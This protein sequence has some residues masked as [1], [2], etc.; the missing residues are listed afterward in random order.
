MG[1]VIGL[2][3]AL[4]C[5]GVLAVPF[6]R[7]SRGDAEEPTIE[8]L[9]EA[10][11]QRESVYEEI[12]TLHLDRG[13]GNV[14]EDEYQE[15]L[16]TLRLRAA[17]ILREEERLAGSLSDLDDALEE[18]IRAARLAHTSNDHRGVACPNCSAALPSTTQMCPHCG[19]PIQA[20]EAERG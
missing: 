3:L 4:V 12:R 11:R 14:S 15:H 13:L 9:T 20:E 1:V 17:A 18:E 2:I 7:G 6:L 5:I 19:A 16:R 10:A 8:D